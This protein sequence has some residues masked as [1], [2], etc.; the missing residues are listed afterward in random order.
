MWP[1][2]LPHLA[3]SRKTKTH[4]MCVLLDT[5]CLLF[6]VVFFLLR[7]GGVL[8]SVRKDLAPG[9]CACVYQ[10]GA[11]R[12]PPFGHQVGTLWCFFGKIPVPGRR[13]QSAARGRSRCL[14]AKQRGRA[15]QNPKG[16]GGSPVPGWTEGT[17]L[18]PHVGI[19]NPAYG[20]KGC[21]WGAPRALPGTPHSGKRLRCL[22]KHQCPGQEP[23]EGVLHP[24]DFRALLSGFLPLSWAHLLSKPS[25]KA[26][27]RHPVPPG[28][29]QRDGRC[30]VHR[31]CPPH[32]FGV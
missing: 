10:R 19:Q 23:A 32:P 17:V 26:L 25:C 11:V 21:R 5:I 7:S 31:H 30:R 29:E 14:P 22:G 6:P 15:L 27:L 13:W 24:Q 4:K 28:R 3:F 18:L 2:G 8:P 16:A 20:A 9:E 12:S 1:A